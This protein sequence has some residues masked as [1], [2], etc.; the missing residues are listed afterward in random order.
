MPGGLLQLI[1]YG[2]QDDVLMANPEITFFKTVFRKY[3]NFSIDTLTT[4]DDVKYGT[5]MIIP[6]PKTGDL[7]YKLYFKLELPKVTANYSMNYEEFINKT[8]NTDIYNYNVKI[9]DINM[10]IIKNMLYSTNGILNKLNNNKPLIESL[11]YI[12]TD[13]TDIKK[14]YNILESSNLMYND[15]NLNNVLDI[16]KTEYYYDRNILNR[17]LPNNT[18]TIFNFNN[19][20]YFNEKN[21]FTQ[22]NKS[23]IKYF[24]DAVDMML[25]LIY[26][27]K[28]E[29]NYI[30][31]N[32]LQYLIEET[33]DVND[34]TLVSSYDYLTDFKNQIYA[35]YMPYNFLRQHY[36]LYEHSFETINDIATK[37]KV[38]GKICTYNN[39]LIDA[40]SYLVFCDASDSSILIGIIITKIN[41]YVPSVDQK[42]T[43]SD[44]YY[45]YSGYIM[46]ADYSN[47]IIKLTHQLD[48]HFINIETICYDYFTHTYNKMNI[49]LPISNIMF[50]KSSD[51]LSYLY[52]ITLNL[53]NIDINMRDA[54]LTILKMQQYVTYNCN[55]RNDTVFKNIYNSKT[56]DV[57][58]IAILLLNKDILPTFDDNILKSNIILSCKNN[59]KAYNIKN[60][61]ILS[62]YV[63]VMTPNNTLFDAEFVDTDFN[64]QVIFERKTK[65]DNQENANSS[66]NIVTIYPVETSIMYNQI[67]NMMAL[68]TR[69][70]ID[71]NSFNTVQDTDINKT[72]LNTYAN[73]LELSD[74]SSSFVAKT[75]IEFNKYTSLLNQSFNYISSNSNNQL[76]YNYLRALYQITYNNIKKLSDDPSFKNSMDMTSFITFIFE[77]NIFNDTITYND[78]SLRKLDIPCNNIYKIRLYPSS[79]PFNVPSAPLPS[80]LLLNFNQYYYIKPNSVI[81]STKIINYNSSTYKFVYSYTIIHIINLQDQYA[82]VYVKTSYKLY[83][84]DIE[85]PN[86]D[87]NIVSMQKKSYIPIPIDKIY[88][89]TSLSNGIFYN[90]YYETDTDNNMNYLCYM[91]PYYVNNQMTTSSFEDIWTLKQ[92]YNKNA[93][94]KIID[95]ITI[96]N[97]LNNEFIYDYENLVVN[98]NEIGKSLF[99]HDIFNMMLFDSVKNIIN[100]NSDNINSV[101]SLIIQTFG[102]TLSGSFKDPNIY[103]NTNKPFTCQE[104]S[105]QDIATIDQS[106]NYA[107]YDKESQN[108]DLY[109]IITNNMCL[110]T[111]KI[112]KTG[113]L[114]VD[115]IDSHFLNYVTSSLILYE[116]NIRIITDYAFNLYHEEYITTNKFIELLN[117]NYSFDNV[118]QLINY[119][120]KNITFTLAPD[121]NTYALLNESV[122]NK[123]MNG[124]ELYNLTYPINKTNIL[125][126]LDTLKLSLSNPTDESY[127]DIDTYLIDKINANNILTYSGLLVFISDCAKEYFEI[128]LKRT[129]VLKL[130]YEAQ[131][132]SSPDNIITMLCQQISDFTNYNQIISTLESFVV[133]KIILIE[134]KT[135]IEAE[136]LNVSS[137]NEIK[138]LPDGVDIYDKTKALSYY[139]CT[140]KLLDEIKKLF[141]QKDT[142]TDVVNNELV[143][144]QQYN[145]ITPELL[146]DKIYELHTELMFSDIQNNI[147]IITTYKIMSVDSYNY[148]YGKIKTYNFNSIID[149]INDKVVKI[150]YNKDDKITI[151]PILI[152]YSDN[153]I[154][155]NLYETS[156][157]VNDYYDFI[158]N[159]LKTSMMSSNSNNIYDL[160]TL[161]NTSVDP[162]FTFDVINKNLNSG[163]VNLCNSNSNEV[164][165][166]VINNIKEIIDIEKTFDGFY[167]YG[168]RSKLY[169]AKTTIEIINSFKAQYDDSLKNNSYA[170][171]FT[172]DIEE[173]IFELSDSSYIFNQLAIQVLIDEMTIINNIN[174]LMTI[175][176][177]DM[178]EKTIAYQAE[179]NKSKIILIENLYNESIKLLTNNIIF[180][181]DFMYLILNYCNNN[182]DYIDT[183]IIDINYILN[184]GI[185]QT[186]NFTEELYRSKLYASDNVLVNMF[187]ELYNASISKNINNIIFTDDMMNYIVGLCNTENK[188]TLDGLY[189]LLNS[190]INSINTNQLKFDKLIETTL[191]YV[192]N[193]SDAESLKLLYYS[194]M[195]KNIDSFTFNSNMTNYIINNGNNNLDHIMYNITG[196]TKMIN[197]IEKIPTETNI[198]IRD[199]YYSKTINVNESCYYDKIFYLYNY[200][201]SQFYVRFDYQDIDQP[202]ETKPEIDFERQYHSEYKYTRYTIFLND[203]DLTFNLYSTPMIESFRF[204]AGPTLKNIIDISNTDTNQFVKPN[205]CISALLHNIYAMLY[206]YSKYIGVSINMN[207]HDNMDKMSGLFD[208][209]HDYN[210]SY[211]IISGLI[212]FIEGYSLI[213]NQSITP[214]ILEIINDN[215]IAKIIYENAYYF[216]FILIN[217][218]DVYSV[219]NILN[220]KYSTYNGA[221]S[222]L[223]TETVINSTYPIIKIPNI[224]TFM[225]DT[226]K[227]QTSNN[228]F[229]DCVSGCLI[230]NLSN[231]IFSNFTLVIDAQWNAY[232]NF[233]TSINDVSDLGIN[234][235]EYTDLLKSFNLFNIDATLNNSLYLQETNLSKL[236]VDLSKFKSIRSYSMYI[237]N[238]KSYNI[239]V[240]TYTHL[241]ALLNDYWY[242]STTIKFTN[243]ELDVNNYFSNVE[244]FYNY[245]VN[246]IKPPSD[247]LNLL[248]KSLIDFKNRDVTTLNDLLSNLTSTDLVNCS[249]FDIAYE[250][251]FNSSNIYQ[252]VDLHNFNEYYKKSL[253]DPV[254]YPIDVMYNDFKNI[255]ESANNKLING[256]NKFVVHE[257]LSNKSIVINDYVGEFFYQDL[258]Y[259]PDQNY[260]K[261]MIL[262]LFQN[263]SVSKKIDECIKI[264][265]N[266]DAN[267]KKKVIRL[268]HDMPIVTSYIIEFQYPSNENDRCKTINVIN[269]KLLNYPVLSVVDDVYESTTYQFYDIII[270][271]DEYDEI[272]DH[273]FDYDFMKNSIGI[274]IFGRTNNIAYSPTSFKKEFNYLD[275]TNTNYSFTLYRKTD[276]PLQYKFIF[277]NNNISDITIKHKIDTIFGYLYNHISIYGN[278]SDTTQDVIKSQLL[279]NYSESNAIITITSLLNNM[280][281]P[282]V[283][284]QL[285][286]MNVYAF[287]NYIH[288]LSLS[289]Y[290][291]IN[292]YQPNSKFVEFIINAFTQTGNPILLFNYLYYESY[293]TPKVFLHIKSTDIYPTIN[294]VTLD[295]AQL[296]YSANLTLLLYNYNGG[297][298]DSYNVMYSDIIKDTYKNMSDDDNSR[299]ATLKIIIYMIYIEKNI[300]LKADSDNIGIKIAT[301]VDKILPLLG[302]A[303]PL[304]QYITLNDSMSGLSIQGQIIDVLNS[305]M[306]DYLVNFI[307]TAYTY[308]ETQKITQNPIL[309]LMKYLWN[310][311]VIYQTIY[312]NIMDRIRS[313]DTSNIIYDAIE[314]YVNSGYIAQN[315][316]ISEINI[317]DPNIDMR[318]INIIHSDEQL[319]NLTSDE[320]EII[321]NIINININHIIS[322]QHK[323]LKIKRIGEDVPE[324]YSITSIKSETLKLYINF[325]FAFTEYGVMDGQKINLIS[326]IYVNGT[327]YTTG[328]DGNI[329]IEPLESGNTNIPNLYP[330]ENIIIVS[331]KDGTKFQINKNYI[332]HDIIQIFI[333]NENKL[334]LSSN[335][336]IQNNQLKLTPKIVGTSDITTT[337][338]T[339]IP[340]T[341]YANIELLMFGFDN[342]MINKY[343]DPTLIII[344]P[345]EIASGEPILTM[346]DIYDQINVYEI[347]YG[348][349]NRS[350]NIVNFNEKMNT[351]GSEFYLQL[352]DKVSNV[353]FISAI[354]IAVLESMIKLN[355]N[356]PSS[357]FITAEPNIDPDNYKFDTS[358]FGLQIIT[359][360]AQTIS[361]DFVI[362]FSNS[363]LIEITNYNDKTLLYNDITAFMNKPTIPTFAYIPYL[364]DFILDKIDMKIDGISVDELR[365]NYMYIYHNLI[366]NKTKRICYNKMN[367]NDERLLIGS[368]T[369]NNITLFIEVPLYFSQISGLS[370]PMIASL[371]SKMDIVIDVKKLEDI[372]I[373]SKF[374]DVNYRNS[375]KFTSIYEVVYLDD[376]EREMFASK[377]H[378]YL[379]Q[380][381]LY[382]AP[383]MMDL[384]T[385]FQTHFHVPLNA[386]ILDYYYYVQ[387]KSMKE[388]KQYYNYTFNYLLPELDM[389]TINKLIYLQQ[390][391]NNN[392]YDDDIYNLYQE[393][394]NIMMNKYKNIL[395]ELSYTSN[396]TIINSAYVLGQY[397]NLNN[398]QLLI[399]NLTPYD[400]SYIENA[401]NTY[402]TKKIQEQTISFSKLYL[403][404][405]ERYN[406]SG[407]YS[408]RI[409]EYQSYNNMIPGLQIYNFS[410]HPTEYQPSGY[411]NF[412]TL[413]PE[414]QLEL[415]DSYQN[416]NKKDMLNNHVFARSYNIMRHISGL[417]GKAWNN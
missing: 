138:V 183:L 358:N 20:D 168:F 184:S 99:M 31:K 180:T 18:G 396:I 400:A 179:P 81:T 342:L 86:P 37:L 338:T 322:D 53:D 103:K 134:A 260:T 240:D 219:A 259:Y 153:V 123:I 143:P 222:L 314:L 154:A 286:I 375:I 377:R 61:N 130:S 394:M 415:D 352:D 113:F 11:S 351:L 294:V 359:N 308:N 151:T 48:K 105:L 251:S 370:I 239:M 417:V 58:P 257:L 317:I 291:I 285:D 25:S 104:N 333:N 14:I 250:R 173:Y 241:Q 165:P 141:I 121:V 220:Q 398:L 159:V 224:T 391:I 89:L 194:A 281:Y 85:D 368:Q 7:L 88:L 163:L 1:S 192:T 414:I 182:L 186:I 115:K 68:T 140:K 276:L 399:N 187:I 211:Y 90:I 207:R 346:Y 304:K 212:D 185:R 320:F 258:M 146:V 135:T 325:P 392:Q 55:T 152:R 319:L 166:N 118:N 223:E 63:P 190:I 410:L 95:I 43:L 230:Y 332:N 167:N 386:L 244:G 73:Y 170:I 227:S 393:C 355:D 98:T 78:I 124:T 306:I 303:V 149:V 108:Y 129:D 133:Q 345:I 280:E 174:R 253:V 10:S 245:L 264:F 189:V 26:T 334:Y 80:S 77:K 266:I 209:Y 91:M 297:I 109:N 32:F 290:N 42:L 376:L 12:S 13:S 265:H 126:L 171:I 204:R 277:D 79:S 9:Y 46:N 282:N 106:S 35:S 278:N 371:Y 361:Q 296:N 254:M 228:M 401:F 132:S 263:C 295:D 247:A 374:V 127:F 305:S 111:E 404:S 307:V 288:Y 71:K 340:I 353:D 116:S 235:I 236:S 380:Q 416:I 144:V 357:K 330:Y 354:S 131:G 252:T 249:L 378:E 191:L 125:I 27:D 75:N 242:N 284:K 64:V 3:T 119:L 302:D 5:E 384:T 233:F 101:M 65:S 272:F 293:L 56:Y 243:Q 411:A 298:T 382:N 310:N 350:S 237:D 213:F 271:K 329:D 362:F 49:P 344:D 34:Y 408:N 226:Y 30:F 202:K 373:K 28:Y 93:T 76:V 157:T 208:F 216:I 262:L 217:C 231:S 200:I 122:A 312:K 59:T 158:N 178:L 343:I 172:N 40:P 301:Y 246:V 229:Y 16:N 44:I 92:Y 364:A 21:Y 318:Y 70:T 66:A 360:L 210:D 169:L 405:V 97:Y 407:D 62:Q 162:F 82:D 331:K 83:I 195:N 273:N 39:Q 367:R 232:Q 4:L 19:Y 196:L 155:N 137:E 248:T 267:E 6:I 60:L 300:N 395:S 347:I 128:Y 413:K 150:M 74:K 181:S 36:M 33:Y 336:Y 51:N 328:N 406:I 156:F 283:T 142:F 112:Y 255:I 100:N 160:I 348:I 198:C 69:N 52:T 54:I 23:Y 214:E 199:K 45:D 47:E 193:Q 339:T 372:I 234:M 349:L 218:A 261:N 387:L 177:T 117:N 366:N 311:N 38:N 289:M 323:L 363:F 356:L 164:I 188:T 147:N 225:T 136:I 238:D 383:I 269:E 315:I 324:I 292:Y 17:F 309:H 388:A 94:N 29:Y 299:D 87:A 96:P 114:L 268:Y 50:S 67:L 326:S 321:D 145:I 148:I 379:Y 72:Q 215:P 313:I 402:Y 24:S 412:Y 120:Y 22:T 389:S 8:I 161:Y 403:N 316:T 175:K 203:T 409:V 397:I 41:N 15:L 2:I 102:F 381:K 270:T 327:K 107:G 385:K 176:F 337:I 139:R 275:P 197:P 84:N 256:G 57:K 279:V 341:N 369:K 201:I 221:V 110:A 287:V 365:D 335:Y 206:Y 274:L 390:T 205:Y